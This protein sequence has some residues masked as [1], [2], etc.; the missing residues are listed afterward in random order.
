MYVNGY[1][2]GYICNRAKVTKVTNNRFSQLQFRV[3]PMGFLNS[4]FVFCPWI[5]NIFNKNSPIFR[6]PFLLL[7]TS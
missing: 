5:V 1:F 3:L 4:N 7:I 2:F 6:D